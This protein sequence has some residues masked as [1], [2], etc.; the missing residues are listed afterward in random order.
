MKLNVLPIGPEHN[1]EMLEILR[2]SPMES[3]GLTLCLDRSPDI[4]AVPR[5]FFDT[6]N[7]YGFFMDDRLAGF[8]MICRK[9]LYVNGIPREIGYLANLYVRPE[10]RKKGWLYKAS[11]PLFKQVME[12]IGF[13]YATTV[14]GNRNTEP[15]VGR[16]IRKFPFIPHSKTIIDLEIKNILITF[17]KKQDKKYSVRRATENDI[18]EIS[19]LLDSE[20]KSRLF[21]PIS[22]PGDIERLLSKRPGFTISD[23]YLAEL[24]GRVVGVCSAWDN[25]NIRNIRVL[26]YRGVFRLVKATHSLAA[27]LLGFP[28]LPKP[29]AAFREIQMNDFAVEDRNPDILRALILRIYA[30]YRKKGYNMLQIASYQGDPLLSATRGFI[31][32]PLFSRIIIGAADPDLVTREEIDCTRPFIDI[33]LT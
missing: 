23:Y 28:A 16:R 30:D 27:P 9:K 15:M 7:A 14:K 5:L 19:R 6:F 29:G 32:Q 12:E 21:G 33:A 20:Y 3:D 10:A 13:G 8:A 2:D 25:S 17:K 26:A 31:T 22:T 24:Q 18:P 4:F 1:E 11:E